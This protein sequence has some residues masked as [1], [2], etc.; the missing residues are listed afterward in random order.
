MENLADNE[1]IRRPVL[2]ASAEFSELYET[3]SR[4]IY[5]LALR[6]IG[7]PVKAEDITHDVFLKAYKHWD[8]FRGDSSCRTWLYRIAINHCSNFRQS[9]H[10]RNMIPNTGDAVWENAVAAGGDSPLNVLETK[11][12]GER[13]QKTLDELSDEHRL[14]L[15]LVADEELSYEEIAQLTEQS[16]DAVRG[17][18]YRAR[19]AFAALFKKNA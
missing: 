6:F 13:I 11:E 9:W 8:Q 3:Y 19:R 15:L 2:S 5:Y 1:S 4:E 14:L 16:V 7:D 18:L 17:K 12:L 10:Q